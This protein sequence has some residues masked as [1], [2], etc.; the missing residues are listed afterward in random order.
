MCVMYVTKL[1]KANLNILQSVEGF[2][3]SDSYETEL[4]NTISNLTNNKTTQPRDN[5]YRENKN[6]K[7]NT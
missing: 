7:Y 2:I 1:F 4:Y 3:Q 5:T 6:A